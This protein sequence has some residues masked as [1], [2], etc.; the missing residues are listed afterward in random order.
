MILVY[1]LLRIINL[2]KSKESTYFTIVVALFGI[3]GILGLA[4][5]L[6]YASVLGPGE[7]GLFSIGQLLITIGAYLS[8]LGFI[9]AL[10]RQIPILLGEKKQSRADYL[11]SIGLGLSLIISTLIAILFYIVVHTQAG[12][13]AY[14]TISTVGLLLVATVFFNLILTGVRGKS[15]T[16]EAGLLTLIKT[17]IAGLFGYSLAPYYGAEGVILAEAFALC[18]IGIYGWRRYLPGV[19]PV[20]RKSGYYLPIISIG[21]PFLVGNVVLNL[22][23]TVDSWFAQWAFEPVIYGQYAFAMIIFVAGQNFTGII[24]QYI[25]PRVFTE[26][27]RTKDHLEVLSKLHRVA[28]LLGLFFLAGAFPF[29]WM[30][31]YLLEI[32]YPSYLEV[33]G[34]A[35]FIY[36]GTGAMGILGVYE[37]Y[38]LA[39]SKG[40]VLMKW[41]ALVLICI[42]TACW[43]AKIN[44]LGLLEYSM[45]FCSGRVLCLSVVFFL[46]RYLVS[47]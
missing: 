15:L 12:L 27:G 28:L 16:L 36:V 46:N 33:V 44:Q 23:Q 24:V 5:L 1:E 43:T 42:C 47:H 10:N 31:D 37:S 20:I 38:V 19:I 35:L 39:R 26:Y 8:T 14:N 7:Y 34:F 25:Q 18:I 21:F 17:V 2:G 41:Y 6:L 9:E 11:L 3:N 29:I 45:I 22:S 30:L 4:R 32:F 13:E 40:K